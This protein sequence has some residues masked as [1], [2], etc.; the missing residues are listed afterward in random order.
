MAV[1]QFVA[2][3][4]FHSGF[5]PSTY[6]I[7]IRELGN[8]IRGSGSVKPLKGC[9]VVHHLGEL[10]TGDGIIGLEGSIAIAVHHSIDFCPSDG[11]DLPIVRQIGK[12]GVPGDRVLALQV[13]EDLHSLRAGQLLVRSEQA[14]RQ[15]IHQAV[16]FHILNGVR[17]PFVKSCCTLLALYHSYLGLSSA[18]VIIFPDSG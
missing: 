9:V 1:D 8:Q 4:P 11:V 2:V 10:L 7:T 15:T 16:D 18:F 14:A 6:L 3:G 12:R 13:V 17:S 5:G